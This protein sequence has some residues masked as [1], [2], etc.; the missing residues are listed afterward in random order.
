MNDQLQKNLQV[1]THGQG[2]SQARYHDQDCS[3]CNDKEENEED[4]E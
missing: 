3:V 1:I 4:K 2:S